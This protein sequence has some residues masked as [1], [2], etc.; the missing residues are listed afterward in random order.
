MNL[1]RWDDIAFKE[2]IPGIVGRLID[3]DR[4]MF[5]RFHYEPGVNEP[6]HRH[7]SKQFSYVIKGGVCFLS[8][9]AEIEAGPGDVVHI[10]SKVLH[11]ALVLGEKAEVIEIISPIRPDLNPAAGEGQKTTKG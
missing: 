11:G 9:E 2:L 10:P 1:H 3:S 5:C 6:I 8:E 4:T 7:E